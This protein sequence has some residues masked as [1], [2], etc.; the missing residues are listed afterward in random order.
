M[1]HNMRGLPQSNLIAIGDEGPKSS[2]RVSEFSHFGT[3][4][5]SDSI[6]D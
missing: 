4:A 6:F 1:R 2:R 5:S 3:Q